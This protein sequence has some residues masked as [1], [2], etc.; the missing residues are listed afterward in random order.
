MSAIN[1]PGSS[2]TVERDS[3]GFD[4]PVPLGHPARAGLPP[5]AATGPEVGELLP[6]FE[7][8]DANGKLVSFH[9]DRAGSKSAL[10]FYRSAVW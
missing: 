1:L 4:A 10:V 7:L 6:D 3:T 2:M 9:Q 5:G 8:Q